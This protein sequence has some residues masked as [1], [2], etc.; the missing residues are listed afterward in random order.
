MKI[1]KEVV[2]LLILIMFWK[3]KGQLITK[4]IIKNEVSD[5]EKKINDE[6]LKCKRD[7]VYIN[8]AKKK[9]KNKK[10]FYSSKN[11]ISDDFIFLLEISQLKRDYVQ[12]KPKVPCDIKNCFMPHGACVLDHICKCTKNYENLKFGDGNEKMKSQNN[13]DD[14]FSYYLTHSKFAKYFSSY[15]ENLYTETF[16]SYHKKYQF[17]AFILECIFIFGFGHFYLN[18]IFHGLLKFILVTIILIFIFLLKRTKTEIKFFT[19]I[20]S[21]KCLMNYVFNFFLF[22]F[23]FMFFI[24]HS[25]DIMML[26]NNKYSDGFGF[27]MIPWNGQQN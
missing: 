20:T 12:S 14:L 9:G 5:Y 7:N 11:L 27:S 3:I 16:C 18:R 25:I 23:A 13:K 19:S 21:N 1:I 2:L 8:N 6:N 24:L 15:I 22:I 17:L 10:L 4:N 26:A